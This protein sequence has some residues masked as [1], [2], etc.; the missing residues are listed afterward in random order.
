M[1][2]QIYTI[3]Q[4]QEIITLYYLILIEIN[5]SVEFIF[6]QFSKLHLLFQ[7]NK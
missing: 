6:L 7:G 4:L 3:M 5:F 2:Y 1:F